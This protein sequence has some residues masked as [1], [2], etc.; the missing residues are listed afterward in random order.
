M[1]QSIKYGVWSSSLDVNDKISELHAKAV[2]EKRDL[3]LLIGSESNKTLFGAARVISSF[4]HDEKFPLW[5]NKTHCSGFCRVNWV[6]IK[7]LNLLLEK[8]IAR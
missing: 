1:S 5:W 2:N 6:Y 7:V 4:N 8:E 3:I